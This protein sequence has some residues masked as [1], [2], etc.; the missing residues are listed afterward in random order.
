MVAAIVRAIMS[1]EARRDQRGNGDGFGGP[2]T[3]ALLGGQIDYA[4]S[5]ITDVGPQVRAGALKAYAIAA[6]ERN[7]SLPD[8]PTT[9]ESGMPEFTA[10]PWFGLFAPKGTPQPILDKLS[11]ALDKALDDP[12]V[13]KRFSDVGGDVPAKAKRGQQALATVVKDEIARWAPIIKAAGLK[14]S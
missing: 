3:T 11:D 7:A 2:V 14:R 10:M 8:V 4:C 1:K 5:G 9:K 6:E 13:R 12:A